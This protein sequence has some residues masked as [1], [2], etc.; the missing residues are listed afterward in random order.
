MKKGDKFVDKLSGS[1]LEFIMEDS[2]EYYFFVEGEDSGYA[3]DKNFYLDYVMPVEEL[4]SN[5]PHT[6]IF[7]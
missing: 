5:H 3:Y 2:Q 1:K 7:K 6:S 4:K